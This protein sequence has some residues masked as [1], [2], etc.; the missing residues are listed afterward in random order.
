M[1]QMNRPIFSFDQARE[2]EVARR[3]EEEKAVEGDKS[4]SGQ[5]LY[6]CFRKAVPQNG[7]FPMQNPIKMEDLGVPLF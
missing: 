3:A 4:W 6:G 7:W 1:R 2:E 5:G